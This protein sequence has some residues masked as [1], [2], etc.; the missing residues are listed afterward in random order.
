MHLEEVYGIEHGIVYRR[1]KTCRHS[2]ERNIFG[3]AG[4][5]HQKLSG[6]RYWGVVIGE[7]V[8]GNSF[9]LL[10]CFVI[11]EL[12]YTGNEYWSLPSTD[13][14]TLLQVIICSQKL[15]TCSH[16]S[17]MLLQPFFQLSSTMSLF[18][19]PMSSPSM[20]SSSMSSPF[21]CSPHFLL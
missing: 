3:G 14:L 6:N 17:L 7:F 20:S 18:S 15:S 13:G 8:R 12:D 10:F 9:L 4:E 21:L 11:N 5:M 19:S 16:F 2:E 1:S